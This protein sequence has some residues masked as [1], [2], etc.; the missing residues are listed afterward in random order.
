MFADV[1]NGGFR[2]LGFG[3]F[4]ARARRARPEVSPGLNPPPRRGQPLSRRGRLNKYRPR[5]I[6]V[7]ARPIAVGKGRC[8]TIR[9]RAL[10]QAALSRALAFGPHIRYV[11]LP[12]RAPARAGERAH[13]LRLNI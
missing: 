1:S 6:F 11:H 4:R 3:V 12:P 5:P 13:P 9:S 2:R 10:H 8:P 7:A